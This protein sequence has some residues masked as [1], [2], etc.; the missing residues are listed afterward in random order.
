[1]ASF[2]YKTVHNFVRVLRSSSFVVLSLFLVIFNVSCTHDTMENTLHSN[3][4]NVSTSLPDDKKELAGFAAGHQGQEHTYLPAERSA[5]S[6]LNRVSDKY[7]GEIGFNASENTTVVHYNIDQSTI[8]SLNSIKSVYDALN[9]DEMAVS[10]F[11]TLSEK[12][13]GKAF[14]ANNADSV[15]SSIMN[16]LTSRVNDGTDIVF[17]IDKTYSMWDDI[18]K[19]KNS[20][21]TI[22]D[23]LS[24]FSNVKLGVATYGDKNYHYNFWYDRVDLTTD[25][26]TVRDYVNKIT[27]IENPDTPES[28]NDAILKTVQETNWTP[29]N[30]RMMLVIGDAPSQEPPLSDYSTDFVVKKCNEMNVKF[31]LYPIIIAVDGHAKTPVESAGPDLLTHVYP[32]PVASNLRVEMNQQGDYLIEVIDEGGRVVM[33][34]EERS[35]KASNLDLGQV[36]NG[37]YFVRVLS[38][39]NNTSTASIVIVQR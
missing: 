11:T 22:M 9:Y 3:G 33:N 23:Y 10:F 2:T 7:K 8:D 4:N 12:L 31:N 30:K 19:V 14:F 34:K 21:N 36:P 6:F 15:A 27:V 26:R 16:I 29:G 24:T 1:M 32:N 38:E 35:I 5:G 28:V 17:V 18:E 39:K 20:L 37:K 13:H 25:I